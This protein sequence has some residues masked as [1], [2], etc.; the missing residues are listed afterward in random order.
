MMRMFF[1]PPGVLTAPHAASKAILSAFFKCC[2]FGDALNG[3][4]QSFIPRSECHLPA[5]RFLFFFSTILTTCT[6]TTTRFLGMPISRRSPFSNTCV[7][8]LHLFPCTFLQTAQAVSPT[9]Q[10][11]MCLN[12]NLLI[13]LPQKSFKKRGQDTLLFIPKHD[14]G[15]MS[16]ISTLLSQLSRYEN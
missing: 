14:V 16:R 12:D 3:L 5:E 7:C 10:R 1:L 15:W 8:R 11:S 6:T 13:T 9:L 4:Q 2:P